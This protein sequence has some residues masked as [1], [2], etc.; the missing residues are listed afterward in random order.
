MNNLMSELGLKC[1]VSST[2]ANKFWSYLW[3]GLPLLVLLCS[4]SPGDT[5]LLS[6]DNRPPPCQNGGTCMPNGD[7]VGIRC[8][9]SP[10]FIGTVCRDR[11]SNSSEAPA[12]K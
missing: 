11:V 4:F 10:G 2:M 3:E 5:Q 7:G 6:C 8:L 1:T 12:G 9:C